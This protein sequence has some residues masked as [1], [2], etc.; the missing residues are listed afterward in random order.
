[1]HTSRLVVLAAS[2]A[3]VT[4]CRSSHG[5]APPSP[6]RAQPTEKGASSF[7]PGRDVDALDQP[8]GQRVVG[9]LEAGKS[10][11]LRKRGGPDDAW[12]KVGVGS[13]D[14]W[15]KCAEADAKPPSPAEKERKPAAD[16]DAAAGFAYYVLSLSWSPAFCATSVGA[17]SPEQCDTT[18]HYGFVVHG[19]WPQNETGW[20]QNCAVGAAPSSKLVDELMD[21]M[22]SKKL[23]SHEWEKHGTCSG[24]SADRYFAKVRAAFSAIRIPPAYQRPKDPFTTS[25]DQLVAAFVA[26]NPK[27]SSDKMAVQCSGELDEVRICLD[28]DLAPRACGRDVRSACKGSARVLPVR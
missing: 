21:I 10:Y 14:G 4:G 8:N 13:T 24:L 27:L 3:L 9:R 5:D 12:C 7:V 23:I 2:L 22:P 26:E 18:R 6:Q 16:A 1:M 20:P 19:L 28:K 15:T 25:Q 17:K 11:P